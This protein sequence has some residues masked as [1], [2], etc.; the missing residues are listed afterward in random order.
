MS[1]NILE[2]LDEVRIKRGL[3]TFDP[4]RIEGEGPFPDFEDPPFPAV[5]VPDIPEIQEQESPLMAL[6]ALGTQPPPA[7]A[8]IP[9]G[10]VVM[11]H[12]ASYE[13]QAVHLSDQDF[14]AIGAIVLRALERRIK[15]QHKELKARLEVGRRKPIPAPTSNGPDAT[16]G[17]VKRKRGRPR[18]DR[19]NAEG[20]QA[21]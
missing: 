17:V 20:N 7:T 1:D 6:G 4:T 10:L 18:K 19:S 8:P 16:V 9:D 13:G 2:K 21:S 3:P 15:E 5:E 11:D 12:V 14:A